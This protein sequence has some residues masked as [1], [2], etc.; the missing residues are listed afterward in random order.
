MEVNF[1]ETKKG[2]IE[3]ILNIFNFNLKLSP[4]EMQIMTVLL[5]DECTLLD[6]DSRE[7]IRK[8]LNK[9]KYITNNYITGLRKKGVLIIKPNTKEIW[10]EPSLINLVHQD[11]ITF[12]FTNDNN[13]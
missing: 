4:L 12:K 10:V 3:A 6:T 7:L 9:D 5:E 8:T 2:K 11:T 13:N 1:K